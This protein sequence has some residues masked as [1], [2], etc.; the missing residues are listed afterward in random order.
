MSSKRAVVELF[1]DV[2]SPYSWMAFEVATRYAAAFPHLFTLRL[3]PFFLGGVMQATENRPPAMVPAK[4]MHL[5]VDVQ[6]GFKWI[7]ISGA[8]PSRFPLSTIKA[9]RALTAISEEHSQEALERVSRSLWEAYWGQDLDISDD[10]VLLACV[11]SGV[12][13]AEAADRVMSLT[14]EQHIKDTLKGA[15]AEAVERGAFGAPTFFTVVDGH[16]EMYFGADRF[17]FLFPAIGVPWNGPLAP[18]AKL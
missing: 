18:A 11:R 1:Y 17:H 4:G 9:Q 14:K 3:R 15:T 12:G 16:S 8:T 7:G 5:T 6:R 13:S 2:V 10:A